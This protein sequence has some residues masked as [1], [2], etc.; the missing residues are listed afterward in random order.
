MII[1]PASVLKLWGYEEGKEI[2]VYIGKNSELILSPK[3]SEQ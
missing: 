3:P 2:Y 1:L